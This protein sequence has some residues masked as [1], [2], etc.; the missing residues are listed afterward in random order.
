MNNFELYLETKKIN[1]LHEWVSENY[2]IFHAIVEKVVRKHML[3]NIDKDDLFQD[4]VVSF[5]KIIDRYDPKQ[6][7]LS[8]FL[9]AVLPHE[10]INTIRKHRVSDFAS[11]TFATSLDAPLDADEDSTLADVLTNTSD[12]DIMNEVLIMDMRQ[13]ILEHCSERTQ[14]IYK[15]YSEGYRLEEIGKLMGL[16]K[17]RIRQILDSLILEIKDAWKIEREVMV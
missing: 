2:L 4:A 10:L 14:N 15:L 16:S 1:Y 8:T 3:Y 6:G 13:Y 11:R 12:Y 5:Y 7:E 17:Q 9:Y